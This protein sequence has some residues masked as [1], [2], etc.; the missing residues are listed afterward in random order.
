MASVCLCHAQFISCPPITLPIDSTR[1]NKCPSCPGKFVYGAATHQ[2]LF[3]QVSLFGVPQKAMGQPKRVRQCF[4]FWRCLIPPNYIK[5]QDANISVSLEAWLASN[6]LI[7]FTSS[8]MYSIAPCVY[9]IIIYYGLRTSLSHIPCFFPSWL[10]KRRSKLVD[11]E[12]TVG[13]GEYQHSTRGGG[14]E[15]RR[16]MMMF[17]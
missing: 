6:V 5:K 4:E 3:F 11:R 2:G 8:K 1:V 10:S 7:F 17:D 13:Q 16:I 15:D 12:A 14:G 9:G